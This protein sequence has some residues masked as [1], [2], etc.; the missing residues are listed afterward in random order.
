MSLVLD[1]S[2]TLAWICADEAPP[3]IDDV[4]DRVVKD[5]EGAFLLVV[6]IVGSLVAV[7]IGRRLGL[8]LARPKNDPAKGLERGKRVHQNAFRLCRLNES[9]RKRFLALTDTMRALIWPRRYPPRGGANQGLL[10]AE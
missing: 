1:S 4:F 5:G 2:A 10:G 9:S 7:V 8:I 6:D 3:G